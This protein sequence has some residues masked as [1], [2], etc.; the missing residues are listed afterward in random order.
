MTRNIDRVATKAST[1]P[2]GEKAVA[3]R[4]ARRHRVRPARWS[5]VERLC[6]TTLRLVLGGARDLGEGVRDRTDRETA[7]CWFFT[8][9]IDERPVPDADSSKVVDF[10][11][12]VP[13]DQR[14][15]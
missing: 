13:A 6:T 14:M 15:C 12:T 8:F 2:T 4:R 11:V 7:R 1:V 10:D 9:T 5:E 3:G